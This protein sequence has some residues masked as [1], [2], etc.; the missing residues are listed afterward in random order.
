MRQPDGAV[1]LDLHRRMVRIRRFEEEAGR[2][3]ETG[4]IP[5]SCTSTSARRR[6]P[7]GVM[8]HLRRRGPGHQ[9][10]PRPR[11][12]H[13]Q[14]RRPQADVSPSCYG[15]AT[16]YCRGKG[17]S[18]HICDPELGMLGA[19][20]IVGAGPPIATGAAFS[21]KYRGTDNVAVAFFG[22][23]A[24]NEG[25]FHEARQPGR[26]AGR[27]RWSSCA[28]TTC[29]ASSPAR[30][31]H[32]AITDI[33]DR[34]A[35]YGIPGVIVDGMDV[36][37]GVRGGRRG[38]RAGARRA[39]ARRCSSARPTASSTTS[40]SAAWASSTATTTRWRAG[41][42]ATRSPLS[43]RAA[44]ARRAVD[45]GR[46]GR[47]IDD[48][49]RRARSPTPI[50]L[51]RGQPAARPVD[52][53]RRR[54]LVRMEHD[55]RPRQS[56]AD[57]ST[58]TYAPAPPREALRATMTA[59]EADPTVFVAG[60]DVALLRRRSSAPPAGC[61]T[62]F[63][64]RRVFD[65][66]ISEE[67]IIGLAVGAA[68]H[69]PA[70]GRR[71]HVHRLR[72]LTCM[73]QICNQLAKM[74]YMFGGK[75]TL[76]VTMRTMAGRRAATL[77]P[78]TR[79]AS[80]RGSATSPGLK[81]VMPSNPYDAKGLL[82]RGH[83]R[84]RPGRVHR[85]QELLDA[86]R[87]RCRSRLYDDP[88]RPGARS[89]ARAPTS[90]SS[91]PARMVAE[92]LAAAEALAGEGIDVEVIDPRTP[93]AARHR[94]HRG[95]GAHG[96]TV[97][98]WCTRRSA[99]AASAPRSRRRSRSWR[100]TTSTRPCGRV[101]APFSPVPFS[102]VARERS[103]CPT[104]AGSPPRCGACS[105]S[106]AEQAGPDR[107]DRQ[108]AGRPRRPPDAVARRPRLPDGQDA[109]GPA[110][111]ARRGGEPERASSSTWPIRTA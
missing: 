43:R 20:G 101:G 92:A 36:H 33:A 5:G 83:P 10:P 108:P 71:A 54:V 76:P 85:A 53:A 26:A 70:A 45:R 84:R 44:R 8:A 104:P 99:S 31:R 75:A 55:R 11:P 65:T 25:T 74:R 109:D 37:G 14:G 18:M 15:K 96:R 66:P 110:G 80:R 16:G 6:S 67:A 39:T 47:A 64:E 105:P 3:M 51:R 93:A 42:C 79:R 81:V 48:A 95:V 72:R 69:R 50:A 23:G 90:P 73:D 49:H 41:G 89:R 9:H 2:L 56:T 88:A 21:A 22:D 68:E 100:S 57:A 86:P 19:N 28:R 87:P 82:D 62:T 35:G 38:D 97:R 59:L 29:T 7:S 32:Q 94:H 63:G 17:G 77:A 46:A 103:T 102:P 12:P 98:W 52:A 111:G 78:S 91:P 4:R 61:W 1:L 106:M 107:A 13:R 40:A 24:S 34:A 27:C 60:E 58:L 30:H